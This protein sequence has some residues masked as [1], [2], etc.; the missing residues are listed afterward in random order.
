MVE[1]FGKKATR[2]GYG[3]GLVELGEKNE[4]VVALSADVCG[5]T[6]TNFFRDRFPKRYFS[7]GIAEQNMMTIAA[8]LALAGFIPYAASYSIFASG[9]AW[10]Q[11]RNMICYCPCN[12]KIVGTHSG[13]TVGPDGATHQAL[14]E[15]ALMRV[16]PRMT[17]I[18][19]ADALEAKKATIAVGKLAGPVYLRVG[20]EPSPIFT[21][22]DSPFQIGKAQ[23]L[24]EGNDAAIVACGLMV[25]ESLLA[26]EILAEK[27]IQARV[28]NLHTIK[29]IDKTTL[30][31][32]AEEC[33]AVVTAEEHQASGGLGGAVAEVLSENFPVPIKR[34]GVADRFGES[35]ESLELLK[36]LNLTSLDIVLAVEQIIKFKKKLAKRS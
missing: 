16:I 7:T 21:K 11:I 24:R 26:G 22:E 36:H 29:P 17:V 3:E 19:P 35:G 12:V 9:R 23:I 4:R 27:G 2:I 34:I 18:V 20:R 1:I 32:A 30:I 33:G 6:A 25:Y 28:I 10:D 13:V 31:T 15:I 8:G 5:S 14:E